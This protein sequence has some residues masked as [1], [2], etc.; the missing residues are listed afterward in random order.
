[1]KY[2]I[3]LFAGF[4]CLITFNCGTI[5]SDTNNNS[6]TL[7][8]RLWI[9]KLQTPDNFNKTRQ[10]VWNRIVVMVTAD[11]MDT[12]KDTIPVTMENSFHSVFIEN[13]SAGENRIVT[14]WTID[15][16]NIIIHGSASQ[17]I[18]VEPSQTTPVTIELQP[19]RSSIYLALTDFPSEIDS[20]SFSFITSDTTWINK[21]KKSSK[22]YMSLDKI[23]F[24][25]TGT[26]LILGLN[27]TGDTITKWSKEGFTFTNTNTTITANFINVGTIALNVTIN[28]PGITL[29]IGIMDT[30]DSLSLENGGI[31]VSEIMYSANDSEY[32]ELY[33]P[34]Q[35]IFQDSIIVQI[36][37][38]TFRFFNIT[39]QPD[40]F[41]VVGRKDMPWADTFHTTQSALNLT[42]TTGNWITIRYARDSTIIDIVPYQAGSNDQ[43]WPKFSS[44]L[45]AS[46]VLDSLSADPKYNNY[47][48]N[49]IKAESFIDSTITQQL[50]TPKKS[51]H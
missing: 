2:L 50:G 25:T 51:G 16:V 24:G 37:N 18:S 47:G 13:V 40:S 3:L 8:I 12:L 34:G 39:I 32:V 42:S 28:T 44:S 48:K 9:N 11:D 45:K 1:M 6:S 27:A 21:E 30:N 15:D 10:T 43:G 33:N 31:I 7:D 36:D 5:S 38:G 49:W 35:T 17:T 14:V 20:V 41:F 19:I 29:I 26:L 23:P 46:I 22:V 4:I